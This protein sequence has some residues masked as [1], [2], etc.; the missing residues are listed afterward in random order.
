MPEAQIVGST[1]IYGTSSSSCAAFFN[2]GGSLWVVSTTMAGLVGGWLVG[3][4]VIGD[5]EAF[6]VQP[7]IMPHGQVGIRLWLA[8][9]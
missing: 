6:R 7:T 3:K 1:E 2:L 8:L 5:H 4:T 9:N